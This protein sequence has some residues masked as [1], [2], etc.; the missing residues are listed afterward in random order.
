M[1]TAWAPANVQASA[2]QP[3]YQPTWESLDRRPTPDWYGDAKFGIFIHW[4]LYSVPAWSPRGTYAEW[5]WHALDGKHQN[6]EKRVKRQKAVNA[7]HERVYGKDFEYADF[8]PL[9]TCEMFDPGQWAQIFKGSGAK[10][11]VLTSK[12]HD[13]YCLFPNQ[14]ANRSFGM[15]WNSVDSGPKRD[16]VRGLTD[17]VRDVGLKM[18]LYYWIWDWF[19][20]YW[21]EEEQVAKNYG[22]G[23]QRY[24]REVMTPQFKQIVRDYQPSLIFSDGDWW[25]DDEKWETKPLL[26]WLFNHAPNKEEVVINDRWG[27]VRGRHGGYYTTE[28]GSG[29]DDPNIL[30]EENRGI[31]KSFGFNREETLADYNS[32][33]LLIYMLVDIVSR[34]GNFLLDVGPTADGRIPV[35]MEDRLAQMGRWLAVNGE[36][37]FGTRPWIKDAQWSE[38]TRPTFTK[39]DHHYGEPVFKMTLDPKP[40]DAVKECWFTRKGNTL[41]ALTPGWPKMDVLKVRDVRVTS[42]TEISLL[43]CEKPIVW[44]QSGDDIMIDLQNIRIHELPCEHIYTF[45]ITNCRMTK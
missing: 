11:V 3:A 8:R 33:K 35:I 30:W 34:G 15:A 23:L 40:G 10:Y 5:Y 20:P 2:G 41:F 38:G 32:A 4:G 27:K 25:M 21:P 12:H 31:G 29:F 28:Y 36:A 42:S 13:G 7:F 1:V 19:N 9:F 26:A 24:V 37:I 16:L 39:D 14:E 22:A 45:A 43:G 6:S 17:A 44:K 18:G